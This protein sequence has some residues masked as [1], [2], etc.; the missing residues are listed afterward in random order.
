V[1]IVEQ[2]KETSV[3]TVG[4][5]SG[6]ARQG[7]MITLGV[8]ENHRPSVKINREAADHARL[9]LSADLLSIQ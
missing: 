7:G 9:R 2:L 3:L 1:K 5:S 4:E 8:K 6:F